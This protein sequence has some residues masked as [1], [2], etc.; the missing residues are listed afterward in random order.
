MDWDWGLG[1]RVGMW[2]EIGIGDLYWG[3]GLGTKI[4]IED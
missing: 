2:I 1:L 4:G 3:M